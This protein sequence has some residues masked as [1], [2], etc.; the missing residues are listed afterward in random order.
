LSQEIPLLYKEARRRRFANPGSAVF[1]QARYHTMDPLSV[2]GSAAGIISIGIKATQYLVDYYSAYKIQKSDVA[3]T[4]KRLEHLLGVLETLRNQLANRKFRADEQ[5]LRKN[6][7]DSIQNCEECTH[8]LQD[9]AVKFKDNSEDGI[10]ATARTA[11]RRVAYPFRQSTLQK[12]EEDVDE[13][14]SHLSLALQGLQV[15]DIGNIRNDVEDTRALLDLIRASQISTAIREWLKAPDAAINYNEACKKRHP[16]TGLWFV[17]GSPFSA[18]LTKPNSFLWLNGFA[19][20][21]KSVLCSTAIQ[22]AFRH[23]RSKPHVGIAFFFFTFNDDAK[24]DS[25]AMLRALVLQLSGQ[26]N[27]NH[28]IL[29]RLHDNYRNAMPPDQALLDCL[30]QLVRAFSDTYIILDALDES[31]RDKGRTDV[32]QALVDLR[33]WSEPGLHLLV[34]SRDEP[35]IRDMLHDELG[36]L[37]DETI[38]L[39]NDSVDSD[40]T[41]FISGSLKNDRRLRKWEK[42]HGQIGKALTEH[43]NGV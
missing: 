11:A 19:G 17:K 10:R 9:E 37:R 13:T 36:A 16:G 35:D 40:I 26:L 1:P 3:H 18:W 2:A 33:A 38:P 22:H 24:Q 8:E 7:E 30:H 12:L 42:Y 27:D 43:A 6:V 23:R 29:S 4:I 14:I 15:A 31:P 39:K 32:L 5:D 41:S 25:S 34:T 28:G 20:C 21:G